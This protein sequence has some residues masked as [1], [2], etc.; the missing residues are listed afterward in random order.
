MTK[1]LSIITSVLNGRPFIEDMLESTP[2]EGPIEHLMIDAGSTDGTLE[3]LRKRPELRLIERPGLP[4]YAAWNEALA[5]AEGN[6]VLFL[7]ADDLLAAGALARIIP[8]LDGVVDIVFGEADAFQNDENGNPMIKYLYRG[9]ELTGLTLNALIFGA[10]I[11]NA[12]IFRRALLL[13]K[14]GFDQ[15]FRFA[16]DRELLL[17]LI[18]TPLN[19]RYFPM[20]L[21]RYRIHSGSMSLQQTPQRRVL[22]AREHRRIATQVSKHYSEDQ[23]TRKMKQAWF[24]H[25]TAVLFIY[26]LIAGNPG[27]VREAAADLLRGGFKGLIAII[28]AHCIR[29]AHAERLRLAGIQ[30]MDPPT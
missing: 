4:L 26:G 8:L 19:I 27:A 12:K 2:F 15:S 5:R 13:Q 21:Y 9:A 7:N 28:A 10:P 14:G 11:I 17:R 6:Y 24:T 23:A 18:G 22:T 3:Q 16:A 29:R 1:V 30:G 25:E 20:L